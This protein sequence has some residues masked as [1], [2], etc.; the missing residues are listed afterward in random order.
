MSKSLDH[1]VIE[2]Y[3][4]CNKYLSYLI[5]TPNKD[6]KA[7]DFDRVNLELFVLFR[8]IQQSDIADNVKT[9]YLQHIISSKQSAMELR[10]SLNL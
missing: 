7:E 3:N 6:L 1:F 8:A 4:L 2:E 5:E 9:D 10:K